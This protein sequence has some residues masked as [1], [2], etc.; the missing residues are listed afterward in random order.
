[1]HV[2]T[3]CWVDLVSGYSRW[4]RRTVGRPAEMMAASLRQGCR[5]LHGLSH[6]REAFMDG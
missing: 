3:N 4:F 2:S 5:W 1:L 6:A